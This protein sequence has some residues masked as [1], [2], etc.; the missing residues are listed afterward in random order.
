MHTRTQMNKSH[1]IR[2]VKKKIKEHQISSSLI[3][4]YP[5]VMTC[6]TIKALLAISSIV[7]GW[8]K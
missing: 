2:P 1:K 3:F 8:E 5:L 6:C 7:G 4:P